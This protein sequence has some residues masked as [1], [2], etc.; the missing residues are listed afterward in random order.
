MGLQNVFP[1]HGE[2]DGWVG[3]FLMIPKV[4]AATGASGNPAGGRNKDMMQHW[5]ILHAVPEERCGN[6]H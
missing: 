2:R 4:T 3:W 1:A 5:Q 6:D